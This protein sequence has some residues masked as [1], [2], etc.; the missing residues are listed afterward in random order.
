MKKGMK[1]IWEWEN[2]REL[3]NAHWENKWH[4]DVGGFGILCINP[5]SNSPSLGRW[6]VILCVCIMNWLSKQW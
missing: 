6:K 4:W 2:V 3:N 1:D 5:L